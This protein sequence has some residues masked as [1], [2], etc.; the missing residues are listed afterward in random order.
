MELSQAVKVVKGDCIQWGT[1][2]RTVSL[3]GIPW[4]LSYRNNTIA[5]GLKLMSDNIVI[6]DAITGSQAAIF[7]S[8]THWVRSLI[9]SF[10]GRLLVSGSYDRSVKLWDVQTG[11][12]V[13]TFY[14][15]A[16]SVLSV[17]I[18][19][20]C[21]KV[22]SGDNDTIS[23]WDIQTGECNHSIKLQNWVNYVGFSP[24]NPEL[25][26]SISGNKVQQ[27]NINGYQTGPTSNAS[28]I[29]FSSDH[30][31]FA[32]CSWNTVTV[33]NSDSGEVTARL[34]LPGDNYPHCCCF[35]PDS[36]LVVA[37]NQIAHAWTLSN[38]VPHLSTTFF[39][40]TDRITC[41]VF[42]SPSSLISA[43]QDRSLKFWQIEG[44]ST[45]QVTTG[46]KSTLSTAAS[47]EFVSLQTKEG[48]AISGDSNGVVKI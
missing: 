39:G 25:L 41:L 18:S 36:S 2:S 28:Y 5:V 44:S 10:D 13:K 3:K 26:I 43:S 11:G 23:L 17:S 47:I 30:T 1:C 35:S 22:A 33:Q 9:F 19:A 6:L 46:L 4:T 48:I 29:A 14:G 8:H 42:S 37:S 34:H 20:D 21:T 32:L 24:T 38:S 12:V 27:W 45:N 7:S 40:H 16:S 15:C 31:Q